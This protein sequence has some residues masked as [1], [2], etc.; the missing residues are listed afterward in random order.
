LTVVDFIPRRCH[1]CRTDVLLAAPQDLILQIDIPTIAAFSDLAQLGA[2]CFPVHADVSTGRAPRPIAAVQRPDDGSARL[3]GLVIEAFELRLQ[4]NWG[5]RTPIRIRTR[6]G[7]PSGQ[8]RTRAARFGSITA[9]DLQRLRYPH[10]CT[11][12]PYGN[13]EAVRPGSRV[14]SACACFHLVPCCEG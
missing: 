14:V 3:N 9:T 7:S 1:E 2:E 11:L 8:G 6:S 12:A 4:Q 13:S 5:R 10:C